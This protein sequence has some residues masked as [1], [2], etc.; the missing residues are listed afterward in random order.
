MNYL[1]SELT[2]TSILTKVSDD[3]KLCLSQIIDE[4]LERGMPILE[5]VLTL[6]SQIRGVLTVAGDSIQILGFNVKTI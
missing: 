1:D 3:C 2:N 4:I 6:L 5:K